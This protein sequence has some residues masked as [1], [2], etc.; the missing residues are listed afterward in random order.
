MSRRTDQLDSKGTATAAPQDAGGAGTTDTE[1]RPDVRACPT[2]V[3]DPQPLI[4]HRVTVSQ[5]QG[6][7]R[8]QYH[9][10][11]TCMHWNERR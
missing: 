10:C 3:E 2:R 11:F 4:Q 8:R 9:K 7:Q 1:T 5:C 6:K